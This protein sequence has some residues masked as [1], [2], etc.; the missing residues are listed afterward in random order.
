MSK[1]RAR[2][3]SEEIKKEV[4]QIL[5]DDIKDPRLGFVTVTGVETTGDLSL[6]RIFYSVLGDD[7]SIQDSKDALASGQGFIRR[8][9]GQRIRLRKVPEIEFIYDDTLAKAQH[10]EELLEKIKD[11][12]KDHE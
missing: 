2:Q 1:Q 4:S 7:K 10:I 12:E 9:I 8:E 5:R 11:D 3:V 6:A